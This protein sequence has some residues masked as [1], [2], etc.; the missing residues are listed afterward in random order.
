ML[1]YPGF[2]YYVGPQPDQDRWD[3]LM[4][5]NKSR[6]GCSEKVTHDQ[7]VAELNAEWNRRLAVLNGPDAGSR[8]EASLQR[9]AA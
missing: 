2:D 5:R 4:A 9:A 8:V 1:S 7:T 3:V 6:K